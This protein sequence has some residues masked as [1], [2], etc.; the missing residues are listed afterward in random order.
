VVRFVKPEAKEMLQIGLGIGSLPK[1][2]EPH[3]I[4][5]DV[6]EIDPDVVR[7]AG[8]SLWIL[9]ARSDP[10]RRR[11]HVPAHDESEVRR[12]R[13]RH[14]HGRV[15]PGAPPLPGSGTAHSRSVGTEGLSAAWRAV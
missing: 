10:C 14:V 3:G 6:V 13:P 9:D 2:L 1:A 15:Q 8:Q 5:V 7:F 11:P 4:K 12:G